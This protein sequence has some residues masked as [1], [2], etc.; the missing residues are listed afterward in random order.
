[1]PFY[2]VTRYHLKVRTLFRCCRNFGTPDQKNVTSSFENP[3]TML[4]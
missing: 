2:L 1:M 4:T 3:L